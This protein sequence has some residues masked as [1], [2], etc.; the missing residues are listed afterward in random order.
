MC[1][2]L[3]MLWLEEKMSDDLDNEFFPPNVKGVREQNLAEED[4]GNLGSGWR[5]NGG[6][7][8]FLGKQL[9][10]S[11]TFGWMWRSG[12][13]PQRLLSSERG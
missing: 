6:R 1:S 2:L 12:H 10:G 4:Q 3:E 9:I 11:V 7:S 5:G 8:M 13:W